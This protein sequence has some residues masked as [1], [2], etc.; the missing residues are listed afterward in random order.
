MSVP[1]AVFASGSGT[2]MQ[3]LLDH[4][5]DGAAYRIELLITDR[6]CAAEERARVLGRAV[7]R[8]EI[9]RGDL[10]G[11]DAAAG[12]SRDPAATP[13]DTWASRLLRLLQRHRAGGILL[14]GFL[15]LLPA[16]VCDAYRDRI[17]NIHPALLPA[18]G[19][20]GMYGHHVHEAVL[21]SGAALSGPTIHFV[22]E[23]YDEGRILAQWPVPVLPGDTAT[24][25]AARVL[26]V[27]HVLYPAAADALAR[28]VQDGWP[29]DGPAP[30]FRWPGG[31]LTAGA[32]S[33]AE[34]GFSAE[35]GS[36]AHGGPSA[37]ARSS[38]AA[39]LEQR[40]Q[41]AFGGA[42]D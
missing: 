37:D 10:S 23:R 35:S 8:V 29:N 39:I 2:N 13:T 28:A 3:A 40:I 34:S 26:R 41:Q 42:G 33:S 6:A 36:S 27:E 20:R 16:E 18:F 5:R 11:S 14:A 31:A 21:R 17:L 30:A 9:P 38:A 7:H 25:L 15:R 22:D 24:A 19:G 1:F 12:A 32:G 4:E